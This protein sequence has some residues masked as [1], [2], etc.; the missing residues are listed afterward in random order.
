MH[1][2]VFIGRS[3]LCAAG[4]MEARKEGRKEVWGADMLEHVGGSNWMH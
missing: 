4:E 1:E 2:K 3:R